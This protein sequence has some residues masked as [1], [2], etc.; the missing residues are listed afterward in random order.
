MVRDWD[1]HD[2]NGVQ[3]SV[4]MLVLGSAAAMLDYPSVTV[5]VVVV[6]TLFAAVR[7][8]QALAANSNPT[9][10]RT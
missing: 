8:L 1:Q 2:R 4:P 3:T 5:T 10:G 6:F 7:A 9:G